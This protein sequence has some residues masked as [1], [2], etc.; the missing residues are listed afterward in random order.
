MVLGD[1]E[2]TIYVIEEDDEGEE[3]VK[4]RTVAAPGTYSADHFSRPSRSNLICYSSEVRYCV[5]PFLLHSADSGIKQ[6]TQLYSFHRKPRHDR[7]HIFFEDLAQKPI[8]KI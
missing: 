3:T 6:A 1:V 8:S 2:E 4:V 5:H 7:S